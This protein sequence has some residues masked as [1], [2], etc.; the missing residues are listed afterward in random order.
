M[1]YLIDI[2]NAFFLLLNFV[3]VPAM[4]YG[5]QLALGALAVT[6]VFWCFTFFQFCH[7]SNDGI[8]NNHHHY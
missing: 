4:T 7:G 5:S 1:D 2:A 8:R 6:I 3:I